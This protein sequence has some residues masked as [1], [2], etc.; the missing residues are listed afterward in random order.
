MHEERRNCDDEQPERPAMTE[1][2]STEIAI[3]GAGVVGLAIAEALIAKG[4]EVT[5]VDPGQPG[6]GASYGNAGTIADG[7]KTIEDVGMELFQLMLDVASGRKKTWAE[8]WKL[9]NALVLF[10][11]APVT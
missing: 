9:H 5:L 7:D 2:H 8:H 10:N 4:H 3:L 1:H 6:M 11:P